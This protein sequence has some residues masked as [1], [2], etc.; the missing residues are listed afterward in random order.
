MIRFVVAVYCFA[1][2][3]LAGWWSQESINQDECKLGPPLAAHLSGYK[4]GKLTRSKKLQKS[5]GASK[6]SKLQLPPIDPKIIEH[7]SQALDFLTNCDYKFVKNYV[8]RNHEK[9]EMMKPIMRTLNMRSPTDWEFLSE[10]TVMEDLN[11]EKTKEQLES[12]ISSCNKKDLVYSY[13]HKFGLAYEKSWEEQLEDF[14]QKKVGSSKPDYACPKCVQYL[15]ANLL[16]KVPDAM[17]GLKSKLK[18]T[19]T[20]EFTPVTKAITTTLTY[21]VEATTTNDTTVDITT[22]TPDDTEEKFIP[23]KVTRTIKC[24]LRNTYPSKQGSPGTTLYDPETPNRFLSNNMVSVEINVTLDLL[25]VIFVTFIKVDRL[26]WFS[27][28]QG[29]SNFCF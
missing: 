25:I 20:T 27:K 22:P 8:T 1:P 21:G 4:N 29:L 6:E 2:V 14:I 19:T 13:A 9:P 23:P 17:W 12:C 18:T 5:N 10:G 28:S 3:L 11:G 26:I 7:S 15:P 24:G 16:V